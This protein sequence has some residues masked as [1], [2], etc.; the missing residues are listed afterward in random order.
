MKIVLTLNEAKNLSVE[1]FSEIIKQL[2]DYTTKTEE[3]GWLDI[4][5][6]DNVYK[7]VVNTYIDIDVSDNNQ[8]V[9]CLHTYYYKK[10][11]DENKLNIKY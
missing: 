3:D 11:I 9:E 1:D 4:T 8:V 5:N 2:Q 6:N 7:M 10:F